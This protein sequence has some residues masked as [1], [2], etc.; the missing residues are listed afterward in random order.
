MGWRDRETLGERLVAQV[1]DILH[2]DD[3]YIVP[4]PLGFTYWAGESSTRVE[5]DQGLFRQGSVTYRVTAR[6]EVVRTRGHLRDV[7]I[8]LEHE[9]DECTFSGPDY[10]RGQDLISLGCGVY[11]GDD[12]AEWLERLFTAAVALQ[13]TEAFELQQS[14]CEKTSVS[15]AIS[16]HPQ[17]GPRELFDENLLHSRAMFLPVGDQ[18]S[19]WIGVDEWTR[20]K[21]VLER[22]V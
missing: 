20:T 15:T 10:D 12:N 18:P 6:T 13:V 3:R 21:W 16:A 9:M 5:T 14:L 2:I 7:A 17:T 4:D 22:S 8:A 1:H 19:A 11:L